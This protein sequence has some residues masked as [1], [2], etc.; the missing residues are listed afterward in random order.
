MAPSIT[1]SRPSS[2]GGDPD[3]DVI[4]EEDIK[5]IC[6][7]VLRR[8]VGKVKM[9]KSFLA[10][11]GDSLLAI[12]LMARSGEKGYSIDIHDI[13]QST[14]IKQLC[15]FAKPITIT[16]ELSPTYETNS[17]SASS[18]NLEQQLG[19]QVIAELKRITPDPVQDVEELF[20]CSPMQESFLIAQAVYPQMYQCTFVVRIESVIPDTPLDYSR[21]R[22][23]W[24]FLVERHA[25]LRTVF[26]DSVDRPGHF[27]QVVFRKALVWPEYMEEGQESSVGNL[28]SRR[29]ITFEKYKATHRVIFAKESPY[30][31][32]LRV[33]MSH[34]VTDGQSGQILLRD[35]CKAYNGEVIS[36]LIMPYRDFVLSQQEMH[37]EESMKYWSRYLADAQPSFFPINGDPLDQKDLEVVRRKVTVD[38]IVLERFCGKFN[39]T[40]ANLCQVAW[41]LVL[42]SY[43]GSE[44]ICF[45]YVTSGRQGMLKGINNTV[46]AFVNTVICR[47]RI[48]GEMSIEQALAQSQNDYLESLKYQ[49]MEHGA[50]SGDFAR[51]KGNTLM[52]CQR[53]PF[54]DVEESG[55]AFELLDVV[56]PTEVR[57]I[58][59]IILHSQE[60]MD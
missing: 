47:I 16:T 33:D 56:N 43:T 13:I 53:R 2:T 49:Y 1:T 51:L 58:P 44:D 45:S 27:D 31:A 5:G 15:E 35:L 54:E 12:K 34:A 25:A 26:I 10:Q 23:A 8:P 52:S 41:A 20:P 38:P 11:G 36:E 22:A 29:P 4:I 3:T 37:R 48:P 40:S 50:Q 6:A 57:R 28:S 19:E 17:Q 18:E 21:L 14:S 46:G 30:K 59:F 32:T 7:E 9:G 24:E 55:M 60:C 39:V 42:R